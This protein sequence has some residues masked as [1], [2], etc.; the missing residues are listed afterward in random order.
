[1]NG[2]THCGGVPGR[3]GVGEYDEP[4]F[5]VDVCVAVD[6]LHQPGGPKTFW[7]TVNAEENLA[8]VVTPLSSSFWMRPVTVGTLGAFGTLGVLPEVAVRHSSDSDQRICTVIY[9]RLVA[10]V[11]LLRSLADRT[12]GT[13][14]DSLEQQLFSNVREGIPSR[15]SWRRYPIVALKAPWAAA[16]V[17]Y[18]L[19]R[20]LVESQRW[21]RESIDALENDTA[22]AARRRLREAQDRM[23]A[24]MRPHTLATFVT[25]AAFN[26]LERLCRRA[27]LPGLEL[28]IAAGV[29]SLEEAEMVAMLWDVS[30]GAAGQEMFLRRYGFHGPGEASPSSLVWRDDAEQLGATLRSY[31]AMP[32][33]RSPRAVARRVAEDKAAAVGELLAAQPWTRRMLARAVLGATNHYFPLRETGKAALLHAIDVCRASSRVIAAD[34]VCRGELDD[35]ADIAFITVE[36]LIGNRAA[37]WRQVTASRK[38][39]RAEYEAFDLPQTWEGVPEPL[40][41][42]E[43]NADVATLNG[44]GASHGVVEGVVRLVHDP[45]GA[46]LEDGEILVCETSDPSWSALFL[47]AAAVVVDVGGPLSH[48]AIVARE[49]G[50]PAVI[51]T[52]SAMRTLRDG[53]KVRVDGTAGVV[54][55]LGKE[56]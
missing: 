3:C 36:E 14:G 55:V 29:G 43:N 21:W 53:D 47:V 26:Q 56:G 46:D 8:G 34:M 31:R 4:P 15:G 9:G 5:G 7:T 52:R 16:T 23:T 28:R 44:L 22:A 18:R 45:A 27:E 2:R 12:P 1:V 49:L 48:G 32:E 38:R 37:D 17:A 42:N 50:I 40:R 51:N 41:R 20:I 39:R 11:D 35:P 25:Q 24:Y 13:S 30:R 10:N 54:S 6:P 33:E 19:R